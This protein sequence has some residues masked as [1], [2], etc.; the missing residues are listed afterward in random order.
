MGILLK[1]IRLHKDPVN[2]WRSRGAKIG[3]GCE[4]YTTA[5]LGSEPYLV[6]LGNHVR[7]NEGVV[8]D[9]H[10][11]GVWVLRGLK[12]EYANI[13]SFGKIKIGNNVHVGNNSIVLP[14]VTIGSNVIIGC[15][16]VVTKDIPDNS[17][18]VGVPAK[19]IESIEEYIKKNEEKFV[20]TKMLSRDDKEKYLKKMFE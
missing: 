11:G 14:G 4:I 5:S 19:V 20:N 16:A 2:Y 10:D 13:D 17:I 8:L 6:K 7:L 1:K 12:K 18:A 15:G 9:T 3:E